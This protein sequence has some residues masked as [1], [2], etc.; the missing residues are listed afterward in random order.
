MSGIRA[1]R[2]GEAPGLME[3]RLAMAQIAQGLERPMKRKRTQ[4]AAKPKGP[5]VKEQRPDR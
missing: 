3:K 1:R 2:C 5:S 4:G